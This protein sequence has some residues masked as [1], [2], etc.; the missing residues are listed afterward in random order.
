MAMMVP[1]RCLHLVDLSNC[2]LLSLC[3]SLTPGRLLFFL[4]LVPV[5][6]REAPSQG[7][8]G[9]LPVVR[10]CLVLIA[11]D[12]LPRCTALFSQEYVEFDAGEWLHTSASWGVQ[13]AGHLGW[14]VLE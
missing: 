2:S 8:E 12:D 3:E 7:H 14:N 6:V 13:R 9:C 11:F 10:L 4:V 5:S 1:E